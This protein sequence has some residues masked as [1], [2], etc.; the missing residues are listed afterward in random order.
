MQYPFV[1]DVLAEL[2]RALDNRD[3]P[4][5]AYRAV[6]Y[7]GWREVPDA[8]EP[9]RAIAADD[10]RSPALRIEAVKALA[11]ISTLEAWRAIVAFV[12]GPT[13][14]AVQLA[15]ARAMAHCLRPE[16]W[17]ALIGGDYP[18]PVLEELC[19]AALL[20]LSQSARPFLVWALDI[21]PHLAGVA[22]AAIALFDADGA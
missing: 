20:S 3:N 5:S 10:T 11:Q 6:Q 12:H 2:R 8:I 7:L 19:R 22:L 9:L 21:T 13:P 4:I 16:Q 17:K 14:E 18:R 1:D 15:A